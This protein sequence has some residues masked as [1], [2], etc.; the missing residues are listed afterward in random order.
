MK[1]NT[2][3]KNKKGFTLLFAV[4]VSTL[5]LSVGAS[6]ISMALKQIILSG[7]SR[8]SQFAFYAANTGI[9]CAIYSDLNSGI[10]FAT[11]SSS[12]T[13]D[14]DSVDCANQTDVEVNVTSDDGDSAVSEFT[15]NFSDVGDNDQVDGVNLEY[16]V[17]VS[18]TKYQQ[19]TVGGQIRIATN[20]L[21]RG[22]NTCDTNNPRRIERGLEMS[23]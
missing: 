8:D 1:N 21:S 18:V 6:I 16:C 14:P 7:I 10:T 3:Q 4:L 12:N 19:D 5:V 15:L 13:S 20:I 17:T 23:Y 9:E 22:Y 11:S 2:K